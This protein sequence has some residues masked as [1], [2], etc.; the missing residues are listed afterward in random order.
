[1]NQQN[2]MN[3]MYNTQQQNQYQQQRLKRVSKGEAENIIKMN[4]GM[5]GINLKRIR[6]IPMRWKHACMKNGVIHLQP[7]QIQLPTAV[8]S[9]TYC[10]VCNTVHYVLEDLI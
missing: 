5:D 4:L 7:A 1:M 9:F 10:R 6:E 2:N 3:Q 8:I